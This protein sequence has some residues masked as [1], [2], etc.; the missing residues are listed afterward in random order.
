VKVEKKGKNLEWLAI[1]GRC[2][3]EISASAMLTS[4]YDPESIAIQLSV[5][6]YL[7]F[8]HNKINK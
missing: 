2:F 3:Y 6:M 4:G 1:A 7:C 8:P 5:S